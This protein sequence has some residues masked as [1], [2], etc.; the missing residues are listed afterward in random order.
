MPEQH[1]GAPLD[2]LLKILIELGGD[3]L[4]L[5]T[6][7]KPVA[8]A[9]DRPLRMTL[10]ATSN[11]MLRTLC[12]AM[13]VTHEQ[14]TGASRDSRFR[15]SAGQLGPF[16]VRIVGALNDG[17]VAQIFIVREGPTNAAEGEPALGAPKDGGGAA[18]SRSPRQAATTAESPA[19]AVDAP[20]SRGPAE[21]I[22]V[23]LARVLDAA[24]ELGAS[25]VHLTQGKPAVLRVAGALA[26]SGEES[27][28]ITALLG[29]EQLTQVQAGTAVD[30][31]LGF[32]GHRL[33]VNVYRAQQGLCAAI[34]LLPGAVPGLEQLRLPD[35]VIGVGEFNRGLVLFCG[36]TGAGK[37]T[38]L[39]AMLEA[40][41]RRRACLCI[42]L[43][44]PIE[45]MLSAGERGGL[46]RQREVGRDVGSF[47][48]GLRDALREDPDVLMIGEMRDEE[49]T[50]LALTA[51]ETGHLVMSTLHTRGAA[52]AIARVVDLFPVG[53]QR[54]LRGQLADSLRAVVSQRLLPAKGGQGRV[55]TAE[56]LTVNAAAAHLIR[57]G[58]LEQLPSVV[59][60]GKDA[61]MLPMEKDLARLVKQGRV[62]GKIARGCADS[63]EMFERFLSG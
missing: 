50:R 23:G 49:T 21:S 13:A 17:G 14:Q 36:D 27:M 43:E 39:A 62:D 19:D 59:H 45:F 46:V 44:S 1:S 10:P 15:Y 60:S 5:R 51:A 24:L 55:A 63:V 6:D 38:T 26:Q 31:A 18:S 52:A 56:V 48:S 9:G 11:S 34:R 29:R 37:S 28:D 54:Q 8:Q 41:L 30:F 12:A 53:N 2:G 16:A 4:Q 7:E 47:V 32:R 58:K 33:R 40:R 61:G 35:A 3:R 20:P 42:T 22:P 57:E 25:D